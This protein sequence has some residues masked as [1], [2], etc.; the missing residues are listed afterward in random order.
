MS[1]ALFPKLLH[2]LRQIDRPGS[3]AVG[4]SDPALLPGLEIADLGPLGLPLTAKQAK[5]LK[6]HCEQAPYGKG[7][8]TL[9]DRSVRRVWRLT[10]DRFM[11]TN[12]DWNR[13]LEQTV[14]KVQTGLG[15]ENQKLESHLYDLLLYEPGSF[16]LPHRDGEK[17]DR[18]VATLVIVLPSSFAGGELIV[19]HEGDEKVFDFGG[20]ESNFRI[21][22][23]AFYADCEHE[24][25]PLR[26]GYRLCLVY[27]L[28]LAKAKKTILAPRVAEPIE[29][30]RQILTEAGAD[31]GPQKTIVT[32]SHQYTEGGLTWDALKGVDRAQAHVL[33][34]AA[35]RA[36][37]CAYLGVLTFHESGSAEYTGGS[38]Y[39]RSWDEYGEG[40]DPSQYKMEE[41][42]ESSLTVDH[43]L[44]GDGKPLLLDS[45]N[46]DEE[47]IVDAKALKKV[48][49]QE[50]FQG[51]TGNEGM[52][53]ERWYR[54]AAVVLWP[55]RR[56]FDALCDAGSRQAAQALDDLV[57][58][59]QNVGAKE[60]PA[61]RAEALAFAAAVVRTWDARQTPGFSYGETRACPLF[62]S[63]IAL[64]EPDLIDAYLRSVLPND[65][66][67][68]PG[69]SLASVC[70]KHGW[71]TFEESLQSAFQQTNSLTATRNSRLL[72]SLCLAKPGRKSGHRELCEVLTRTLFE[73]VKRIDTQADANNWYMARMDRTPFLIGLA[74]GA[75]AAEQDELLTQLVDHILALPKKYPL[76]PAQMS[77]L[78]VLQPWI[79]KHVKRPCAPLSRWLAVCREQLEA[80]TA[81]EPQPPADFR[82]DADISC[83]C[84]DCAELKRFLQDPQ[85]AEH[86]FRAAEQRRRHLEQEI[87]HRHCDL[88]C[89]TERQGSPHSLVCTK[90]TATYR[91][92]LKQYHEDRNHL[93]LVRSLEADVPS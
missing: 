1:H 49:P 53:L 26:A 84:A 39:R 12:P 9:V 68:D 67:V 74:H 76:L 50:E 28:T 48:K 22:Y 59:G 44:D 92:R 52:T 45:L 3:F 10:P 78:T 16:F 35:R 27:N 61:L 47:E 5:E 54:H 66:T 46:V 38:R 75:L 69:D 4:G 91:E 17:L 56:H 81:E 29:A 19:R 25:R 85:E 40:N 2:V 89:R 55:K 34:E 63:L 72:H 15:L 83:K 87:R 7:Q 86:R 43:L 73:C 80:R 64:D 82:R 71:K 60:A 90:N 36:D 70:Q 42:Y 51:Y 20:A 32:L 37:W 62:P 8:E 65:A 11:L 41:V 79:K 23:A 57:K 33:L 31:E 13:F 77:A 30:L 18:M 6:K 24:I 21:H 14:Q 58:R 93:A 88:D